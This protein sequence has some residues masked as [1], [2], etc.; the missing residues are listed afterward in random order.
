MP[1]NA[2]FVGGCEATEGTPATLW[3]TAYTRLLADVPCQCRT[4]SLTIACLAQITLSWA[5]QHWPLYAIHQLCE[6]CGYVP[7]K[8]PGAMQ[9]QNGWRPRVMSI[10]MVMVMMM[11]MMMM[12]MTTMMMIMMM[13]TMIMMTMMMMMMMIIMMMMMMMMIIIC[14][15]DCRCMG[16]DS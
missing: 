3:P 11:M 6:D 5:H 8:L 14:Q 15:N 10:M 16:S 13:M 4:F 12:M 7:E 1:L 9:Y 2:S